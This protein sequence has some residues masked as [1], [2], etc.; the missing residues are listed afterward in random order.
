M[1]R[2]LFRCIN[3]R[4]VSG[5]IKCYHTTSGDLKLFHWSCRVLGNIQVRLRDVFCVFACVSVLINEIPIVCR[6]LYNIAIIIQ[7]HTRIRRICIFKIYLVKSSFVSFTNLQYQNVFRAQII[8]RLKW[9]AMLWFDL[10]I[11]W[12]ARRRDQN[13]HASRHARA[14]ITYIMR[15]KRK[16]HALEYVKSSNQ[17]VAIPFHKTHTHHASHKCVRT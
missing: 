2:W 10:T 14:H 15:N 17:P 16:K 12:I 1:G 8:R 11:W 4:T 5:F 6:L 13:V 9:F 3:I 7:M